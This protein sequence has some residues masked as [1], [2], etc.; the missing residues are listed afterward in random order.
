MKE[1]EEKEKEDRGNVEERK[2]RLR[3]VESRKVRRWLR[4]EEEIWEGLFWRC[5]ERR[6]SFAE[7]VDRHTGNKLVCKKRM[8]RW[9]QREKHKRWRNFSEVNW[10]A[11]QQSELRA[12][13]EESRRVAVVA[14]IIQSVS[15]N[16][17][18]AD[19]NDSMRIEERERW[20]S[21]RGTEWMGVDEGKGRQTRRARST[22][23]K[24]QGQKLGG[25]VR[26]V[27]KT[28]GWEKRR[29]EMMARWEAPP[30]GPPG[31]RR[32]KLG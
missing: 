16:R 3:K 28:C 32:R 25:G 24:R 13:H 5:R 19:I 18:S 27:V 12:M 31:R 2:H 20:G 4:R 8:K 1:R 11:I 23:E 21:E 9:A 14:A 17:I 22:R 30:P 26:G 10:E 29:R 7:A 6:S 15:K